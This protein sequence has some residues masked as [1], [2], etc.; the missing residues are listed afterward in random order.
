[1]KKTKTLLI[2]PPLTV[3]PSDY[4]LPHPPLGLA[5]LAA[6]LE[7]DQFPV[8]ILDALALGINKAKKKKGGFLKVGLSKREIKKAVIDFQPQLVGI[9]CGSTAHAPD[10]HEVAAWVKEVDSKTLVV[11][12]GAHATLCPSSVLLDVN[13]DL[14]VAGEGEMTILELV[15]HLE[16]GRNIL[17][18]PGTCQRKGDK[19]VV[20]SRRRFITNLDNLPLPARHLLPME[21]YLKGQKKTREFSLRTP[22]TAMITSRGCPMNCSFC[23]VNV[24]WGR[25][26]RPRS[27]ESVVG[28][29]EHLINAY[30]VKEFYMIDDNVTVDKERVVKICELIRRRGLDIRWT[31]PSGTAIWTLDKELLA[32]MKKSGVYRLTFGI[33]SGCSN[34]LKTIRKPI[35]LDR[36]KKTIALCNQLGFWT[37]SAFIIGFPKETKKDIEE[38]VNWAINSGLD[39]AT[40]YVATPYPGTDLHQEF[41]EEG[42]LK[43]KQEMPYVSVNV[44]S[45]DTCHF[46]AE[47]LS[48]LKNEALN[49]FLV[50]QIKRYLNPFYTLPHLRRKI[51]SFEEL[52]YLGKVVRN[53]LGMKV[54]SMRKGEF[55]VFYRD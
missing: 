23:S 10:S 44:A 24:L 26:W 47:E 54:R 16:G 32:E 37:L 13:V 27:P 25:C 49:R 39:F 33:E 14:I 55:R 35:I 17:G 41:I 34:T 50:A 4:P 15:R 43:E 22:R 19:V 46:T 2:F 38:T 8:K 6:V 30:G 3:D 28:E 53:V 7:K 40:F 21:V 48:T 52:V 29:M 20:N 11:F 9:W 1:M 18:L 42:L 5:Y 12:G 51:N 36:V 45:Y 31:C